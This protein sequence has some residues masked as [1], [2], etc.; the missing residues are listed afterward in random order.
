MRVYVLIPTITEGRRRC[1]NRTNQAHAAEKARDRER[2]QVHEVPAEKHQVRFTALVTLPFPLFKIEGGE[3]MCV[4]CMTRIH[5]ALQNL[6]SVLDGDRAVHG[7]QQ[8]DLHPMRFLLLLQVRQKDKWLRPLSGGRLRSVR[9][10]GNQA[11][12]K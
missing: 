3:S 7:M 4:L 11:M 5:D 9:R 12:G 10:R 1:E 8:N 6:P 2:T